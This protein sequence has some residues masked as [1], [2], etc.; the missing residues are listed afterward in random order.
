MSCVSALLHGH[1]LT[2]TDLGRA[3]PSEA[4]TKHSIKR[5]DRLLGNA[6]LQHE[7]Q[8]FYWKMLTALLGSLR[9]PLILVDWSPINAA[10]DLYLLRASIPQ[11]CIRDSL[12]HVQP[13]LEG[14][15]YTAN[16]ATS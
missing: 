4:Y 13:S 7:R 12:Y 14:H 16:R 3:M 5:V 8:L 2:L 15:R 11:M 9:H 6:R 1:R 10:S